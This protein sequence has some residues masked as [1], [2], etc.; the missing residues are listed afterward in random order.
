VALVAP[1]AAWFY[2]EPRLTLLIQFASLQFLL[3]A[4]S[5]VPQALAYR[6]MNFRW[7]AHVEVATIVSSGIATLLLAWNGYGVWA[8]LLGS[9]LQNFIRTVLLLRRGMPTPMFRREGLRQHLT[10]GGTITITRLITQVVYQSDILIAGYLLSHQAIGLYSVSLHLATLP[11]QKIMSVITQVAFP[12]VA[13]LQHDPARLRSRMLDATRL[14][15][16][17]SLPM[18]WGLSAVAPE[19]VAIVM[20]SSWAEA[21]FPLQVVCLVIPLRMLNIFYN[22]VTVGVGNMQAS[23]ANM[24]ASAIVLPAT[25]YVGAHWGVNGLA[26]AWAVAI[27]FVFFYCLPRTLRVVDTRISD[28]VAC[29]KVP[30]VAGAIM[31]AA[32]VLGRSLSDGGGPAIRLALLIVLGAGAYT[33]ALLFLDRRI[34]PDIRHILRAMRA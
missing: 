30:V 25:F 12:A 28:L 29:L 6:D 18:L 27:P 13:K 31:Y 24:V 1:L 9:L 22:T 34:V 21:V 5:T 23:V 4:L 15:M 26:C 2:S 32:V 8:L 33:G 7:L 10:F 11:M 19:F 14:L 3:S 17:F 20:G 16:V